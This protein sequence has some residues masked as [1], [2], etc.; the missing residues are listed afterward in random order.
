MTST[1]AATA[2][3]NAAIYFHD[4]GYRTDQPKLMGRHA[5]GEG[6]LKG[7]LDHAAIGEVVAYAETSQQFQ[8][9]EKLCLELGGRNAALPR[10]WAGPEREA[11]LAK[12]GALM[13]PGP[14]L[15]EQGW[16]RRRG[17]PRRWSICGVTHTTASH[18]AMDSIG[19]LLTGPVE[20]WDALICT[21]MA[22][23]R[24]V[25]RILDTYGQWL[26]Q[27]LGA[28][29]LTRPLLPV[30]PLG[31][32]CAAL[33]PGPEAKAAAR[34]GWRQR[35]GIAPRDLVVLFVGRLSWHAKAHPLPM[36]LGLQH[37]ARRLGPG[38]GR[39]HLVES[40]WHANDWIRDGFAEA[41]RQ[42]MPDVQCH[43]VDGR[44][45]E[46]R[47]GVWHAADVFCSLSDNIQE[48]YGLTPVEAMAAGLP[49]VAGDW[50]GYRDTL[51]HGETALLV[52]TTLPAP[53]SGSV[54]AERHEDGRDSYDRY[55]AQASLVTAVDVPAAAEAL[56]ALLGDP[57][58]RAAMGAAG[59]AS[60]RALLDW[61]VV[62]GRYQELWAEQA[63][64]RKAAAEPER[65][66]P[67]HPL[68]DNPFE[69]F[70][71]YATRLLQPDTRLRIV[72]DPPASPER[73]SALRM[74]RLD[75]APH[76]SPLTVRMLARLRAA[77]PAGLSQAE[78]LAAFPQP[79][80]QT[81]ALGLGWLLKTG[82]IA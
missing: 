32:D 7:M 10:L 36:Y 68:R 60:A 78:L 63:A 74:C 76:P 69:L 71:H 33:D 67:A 8:L 5:A 23:R 34:A 9:F 16:R 58:R 64:I 2:Q 6:F 66:G 59:R 27:R 20:P 55:C 35:L 1:V 12:A 42:L 75:G 13:L 17:S 56:T 39:L 50:D 52:P 47:R 77:G 25:E 44:E 48:T 72:L 61:R 82:L 45:P 24:T 80:R 30:I 43:L 41:Q 18:R 11:A 29:R 73:V 70:G 54:F 21:S 37:A 31:I 46:A 28:A 26:Q 38:S 81:A 3:A 79:E 40:G 49:V 22:V 4:E 65:Q 15:A 19:E 57:Q 14:N 53:G 62:I 51:V